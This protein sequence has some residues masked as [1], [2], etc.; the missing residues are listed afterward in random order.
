M[1]AA[2]QFMLVGNL[3][4]CSV[5]ESRFGA[6]LCKKFIQNKKF[7]KRRKKHLLSTALHFPSLTLRGC[8]ETLINKSCTFLMCF[9][10]RTMAHN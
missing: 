4:V 3:S 1:T 7:T 2:W 5:N 9:H 6:G 8:L 10:K